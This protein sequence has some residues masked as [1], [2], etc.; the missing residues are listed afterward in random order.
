M[1]ENALPV[2]NNAPLTE[3]KLQGILAEYDA[4]RAEIQNRSESQNRLL[5]LHIAALAF[6][7]STMVA[8]SQYRYALILLIPIESSVFGLWYLVHAFSIE[9]I[10]THIRKRIE[11]G[12]EKLVGCCAMKWENSNARRITKSQKTLFQGL[13]KNTFL[14]HISYVLL[15]AGWI[16]LFLFLLAGWG[17]IGEVRELLI[18]V[19][20]GEVINQIHNIIFVVILELA[21]GVYFFAQFRKLNREFENKYKEN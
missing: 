9:E 17:H 2:P 20:S 19:F 1:S 14:F 11:P 13:R 6:I 3:E 7:I 18:I 5:E 21:L 15:A 4:L 8:Y 10:G 16:L 12:V